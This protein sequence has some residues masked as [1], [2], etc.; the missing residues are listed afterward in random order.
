MIYIAGEILA[1]R[2]VFGNDCTTKVGGAPFNAAAWAADGGAETVFYGA[3]GDDDVGKMVLEDASKTKVRLSVDVLKGHRTTVALVSLAAGGERN[4]RFL[5]DDTA[6][7][8]LS[9]QKMDMCA[10]EKCKIAHLGSLMLT[11]IEG[12][13]FAA[14]FV[15]S[16]KEKRKILSF[17]Y[18]FRD[19]LY[20]SFEASKEVCKNVVESADV[21]KFSE[22]E[23]LAYTKAADVSGALKA[24]SQKERLVVVTLGK[25][26]SAYSFGGELGFVEAV[27]VSAVDTTGAGDAYMGTMLAGL[28]KTDFPDVSIN[29]IQ[30]VLEAAS[31]K[32]AEATTFY[33]AI[34]I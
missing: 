28:D 13:K 29:E 5:R 1:D 2:F 34:K 25:K 14:D 26:G 20:P 23:I 10:F 11:E 19:D 6:E 15:A 17:D 32:G 4:F 24:L 18:N 7:F 21:L 3:V 12:R 8:K 9:V 30:S 22:D 31:R 27:P 33:G 16:S